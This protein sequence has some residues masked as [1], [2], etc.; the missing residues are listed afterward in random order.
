MKNFE[1]WPPC[2]QVVLGAIFFAVFLFVM[3]IV[4]GF[5]GSGK[6]ITIGSVWLMG[7]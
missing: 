6:C 2:Y 1:E 3:S 4:L 5:E 7:C